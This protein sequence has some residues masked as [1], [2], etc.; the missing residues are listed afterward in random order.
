MIECFDA[1]ALLGNGCWEM[2]QTG[3]LQF[4]FHDL[5]NAFD[6]GVAILCI[7]KHHPEAIRTRHGNKRV[8]EILQQLSG[9]FVCSSDLYNVWLN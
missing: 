7:L 3:Y 5:H 2:S 8:A 9:V 6:S 1:A 4:P